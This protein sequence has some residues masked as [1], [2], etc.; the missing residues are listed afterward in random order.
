[1]T[2]TFQGATQNLEGVQLSVGSK[3]LDFTVLKTDLSPWSLKDAG[4]TVKIISSVPSLDT[5]VCD[6]QS[7]RFNKEAAS[8][9]GVTV[10]TISVDLPF[11]QARWCAA[12]NANSHIVA[13][14][15][16]QVYDTYVQELVDSK[17]YEEDE[18]GNVIFVL[19]NFTLDELA[20]YDEIITYNYN[21]EE[22]STNG[23]AALEEFKNSKTDM[24]KEYFTYD[25]ETDT[26]TPNQDNESEILTF[27]SNAFNDLS[28]FLLVNNETLANAYSKLNF[29]N[30]IERFISILIVS[31]VL[32]IVIPLILKNGQTIGKKVL[33][34][35]VVECDKEGL[36]LSTS[37]LLL[38]EG[39]FVVV[40]VILSMF[41]YYI[42]LILSLIV[43]VATKNRVSLHDVVSRTM[44]IDTLEDIPEK[45]EIVDKRLIANPP[46]NVIENINIVEDKKED[47]NPIDSGENE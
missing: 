4:D 32:Y 27:Y 13:S 10:V 20:T 15:Y 26:Y 6:V 11:A 2:V 22:Y 33:K 39:T 21:L 41:T 9:K 19:D 5:P 14:D 31:V 30:Q 38:R 37:K 24:M 34:V 47:S 1:M 42:P 45:E 12:A 17:M 36:G 46:I 25:Q 8:L 35:Y 44:V 18:N 7:K 28:S 29:Y 16:N 43:L 3:A 40:E 23:P